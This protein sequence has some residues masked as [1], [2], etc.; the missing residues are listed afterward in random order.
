MDGNEE[1]R[2]VWTCKELRESIKWREIRAS[3]MIIQ[4][5]CGRRVPDAKLKRVKL[6][7]GN[8]AVLYIVREMITASKVIIV[9]PD[10]PLLSVS[11]AQPQGMKDVS[12]GLVTYHMMYC[13]GPRAGMSSLAEGTRKTEHHAKLT[14]DFLKIADTE[15]L[16][17]TVSV[18]RGI[19]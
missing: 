19:T 10:K 16:R 6:Y 3:R 5:N 8:S 15:E 12:H 11:K 2:G 4:S 7:C 9:V 14:Y 1:E 13:K 18:V 17:G